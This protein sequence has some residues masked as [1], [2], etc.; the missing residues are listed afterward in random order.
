[1]Y[2]EE[3]FSRMGLPMSEYYQV[4]RESTSGP[5]QMLKVTHPAVAIVDSLGEVAL[6]K[7]NYATTQDALAKRC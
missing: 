2:L 5:V 7:P 6:A 1:M 4:P 3:K